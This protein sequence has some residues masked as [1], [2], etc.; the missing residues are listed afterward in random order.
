MAPRGG[1]TNTRT[2]ELRRDEPR[3]DP[4]RRQAAE[5]GQVAQE[6][7]PGRRGRRPAAPRRHRGA[8][9]SATASSPSVS[10]LRTGSAS[11]STPWP[12]CLES[13]RR[14]RVEIA[15]H[16]VRTN[17]LSTRN[18]AA[19]S[20]ATTRSAVA[21][22]SAVVGRI[23]VVPVEEHDRDEPPRRLRQRLPGPHASRRWRPG[24]A[25]SYALSS[26]QRSSIVSTPSG[27]R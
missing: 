16:H 11:T 12:S 3:G 14:Q 10:S 15:D 25:A 5:D 17:P 9:A 8:R 22:L 7:D 18:A 4:A 1:A 26:G 13:R 2:V 19:P 23:L 21:A 6:C 27:T 24:K 20:A